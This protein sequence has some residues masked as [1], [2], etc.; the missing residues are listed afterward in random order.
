M[1]IYHGRI[2]KKLPTTQIQAKGGLPSTQ[3]TAA[4][5]HYQLNLP[6]PLMMASKSM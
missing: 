3:A 2:R 1:V 5:S 4:L 6:S